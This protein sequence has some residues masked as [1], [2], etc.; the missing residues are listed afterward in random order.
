MRNIKFRAWNKGQKR[1]IMDIQYMYDGFVDDDSE[2]VKKW[3]DNHGQEVD[4]YRKDCDWENQMPNRSFGEFLNNP[5]IVVMQYTGLKDKNGVKVYEGDVIR[6]RFLNG[7][8]VYKEGIIFS[9]ENVETIRTG[10]IVF[11]ELRVSYLLKWFCEEDDEFALDTVHNGE[12]FE[13]L[14]NIYENPNLISKK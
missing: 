14:G 8:G 12:E 11:D 1:M 3:V 9:F 10:E 5:K 7:V 4:F 6:I 2:V 13:V